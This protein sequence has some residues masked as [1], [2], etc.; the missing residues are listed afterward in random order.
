MFNFLE[1]LLNIFQPHQPWFSHP[2]PFL[3]FTIKNLINHPS[4][5][6][7]HYMS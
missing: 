6:H 1:I 4:T 5:I 7:S 3:R 2:S